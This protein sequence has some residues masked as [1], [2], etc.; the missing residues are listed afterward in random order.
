MAS[1][2]DKFQEMKNKYFPNGF[3]GAPL[4]TGQD[5]RYSRKGQ[6]EFKRAAMLQRTRLME[7]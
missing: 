4:I 5:Y 1:G 6:R 7:A 3:S 2:Y